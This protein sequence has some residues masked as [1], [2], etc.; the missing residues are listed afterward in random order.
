M[1][2]MWF[3]DMN[4]VSLWERGWRFSLFL[5]WFTAIRIFLLT[6]VARPMTSHRNMFGKYCFLDILQSANLNNLSFSALYKLV[7]RSMHLCMRAIGNTKWSSHQCHYLN[8]ISTE[9]AFEKQ[10]KLWC[11]ENPVNVNI[12]WEI[13]YPL[14]RGLD[15]NMLV[16]P[17][18]WDSVFPYAVSE[19]QII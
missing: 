15:L 8:L 5:S 12:S 4:F 1:W 18:S 13:F 11:I 6:H 17:S 16:A 19:C 9:W 14:L 10:M 7:K 3:S 2:R